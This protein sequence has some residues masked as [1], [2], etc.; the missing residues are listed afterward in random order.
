MTNP[1]PQQMQP[2]YLT[3]YPQPAQQYAPQQ[4]VQ[5]PS[6]QRPPAQQPYQKS[7]AQKENEGS[8][9]RDELNEV[10]VLKDVRFLTGE[11]IPFGCNHI[12]AFNNKLGS[13]M[14]VKSALLTQVVDED[15][16]G[17]QF[18]IPPVMTAVQVK[19]FDPNDFVNFEA[20]IHYPEAPGIVQL[21]NFGVHV[22]SSGKVLYGLELDSV[23]GRPKDH[24][25]V[26]HLARVISDIVQDSSQMMDTL[27]TDYQRKLLD[28]TYFGKAQNRDKYC[29]IV[30]K[31][32]APDVK[33]K[34]YLDGEERENELRQVVETF[35]SVHDL[36]DGTKVLIG[37]HGSI[38][39]AKDYEKFEV[40]ISEYTFLMSLDV[41]IQNLFSRMFLA[42][43]TIKD[44]KQLID[45]SEKEPNAVE[46]AQS[47]LSETMSDAVL[48][49]EIL[50]YLK[51]STHVLSKEWQFCIK[52]MGKEQKELATILGIES[53]VLAAQEQVKDMEH[54]V[55]GLLKSLE[56][57][58]NM[59][60]TINQRQMRRF[61]ETLEENA[62]NMDSM[63]R[64]SERTG[65]GVA[66][67]EIILSGTLAFDLIDLFSGGKLYPFE[68]GTDVPSTLAWSGI[69]VGL[70]ALGSVGL[71][72]AMKWLGDRAE[73][74]VQVKTKVNRKYDPEALKAYF[75]KREVTT[76]DLD[77]VGGTSR[78]RVMWKYNDGIMWED[79]PKWGKRKVVINLT[80]D[81]KTGYILSAII[82]VE[83]P[84]EFTTAQAEAAFLAELAEEKVLR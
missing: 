10:I 64:A 73:P 2:P 28:L 82:D 84:G 74:A 38:L 63:A 60:E 59:N 3:G 12:V 32:I 48:M 31:G 37:T 30:A 41:F 22:S 78:K 65:A 79:L 76:Q 5:Q 44:I 55:T 47:L 66:V 14:R 4:I 51:E 42:N 29:F 17:T 70:W 21:E 69:V 36:S 13:Y 19:D 7:E 77:I 58:S 16:G 35:H 27:L 67:M 34:E 53:R 15:P 25:S 45:N 68:Y 83:R 75:E 20:Q 81:E 8:N 11:Y 49:G 9:I 62:R 54:I 23:G 61:Q 56:G 57:L 26:D 71:F 6:A 72:V 39:V 50:G 18:A 1:Q 33:A 52:D 43:D 24:V 80:Y 40:I 46:H